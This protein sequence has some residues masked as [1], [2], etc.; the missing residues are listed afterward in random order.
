M[1]VLILTTGLNQLDESLDTREFETIELSNA[2]IPWSIYNITD[3]NSVITYVTDKRDRET[4]KHFYL[5]KGYYTVESLNKEIKRMIR[6][7][8]DDGSKFNL[9]Y[10]QETGYAKLTVDD[11]YVFYPRRI[12][13]LIG[14]DPN[15]SF[16]GQSMGRE[17]CKMIPY[18]RLFITCNLVSSVIHNGRAKNILA[19]LPVKADELGALM[20]YNTPFP[21]IP[22]DQYDYTSIEIDI[23]DDKGVS[24]PLKESSTFVLTLK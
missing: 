10:N 5:P 7:K 6:T 16:T 8:G 11:P 13:D 2:I 24:I 3:S 17:P 1:K 9:E 14:F 21:C 20:I 15:F 18:S 19:V 22:V 23:V 4:S 12:G